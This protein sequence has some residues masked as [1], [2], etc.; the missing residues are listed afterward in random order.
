MLVQWYVGHFSN[1][2]L[3]LLS[4]NGMVYE[5]CFIGWVPCTIWRMHRNGD[6]PSNFRGWNEKSVGSF[7]LGHGSLTSRLQ[8]KYEKNVTVRTKQHGFDIIIYLLDLS[9]FTD[10]QIPILPIKIVLCT[11]V[12]FFDNLSRNSYLWKELLIMMLFPSTY[13]F[14]FH[15]SSILNWPADVLWHQI[16]TQFS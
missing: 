8:G 12:P 11:F 4:I 2:C 9:N 7:Q 6:I 3:E 16:V 13:N 15:L 5:F 1:Q 10:Y 14:G